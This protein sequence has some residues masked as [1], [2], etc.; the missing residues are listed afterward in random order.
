M[1]HSS[2][3]TQRPLSPHLQVYKPQITSVMS[4]LHRLTGVFL[5]LGSLVLGVWL[6]TAAYDVNAHTALSQFFQG[7]IGTILLIAWSAAF[8]YHLCN[9]LRHL[10][11]DTG[12]GFA[13]DSVTK[14]GMAVLIAAAIM[15]ATTWL[16]IWGI[17]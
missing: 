11:W 5:S 12:H 17:I 14:S 4:I 15:T 9:G 13:L 7:T 6:F 3:K 10:L 16:Y 2:A 8:Y 1:N